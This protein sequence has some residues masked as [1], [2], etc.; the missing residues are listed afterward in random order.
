M[1][2]IYATSQTT[3]S[4]VFH[5]KFPS[6]LGFHWF[7]T[8]S[9]WSHRINQRKTLMQMSDRLLVD[10]GLTREQI[11]EECEKPFWIK[12]KYCN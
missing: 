3:H 9:V 6:P 2:E 12:G 8:V 5:N 1:S 11:S 7:Q 10:I 4:S